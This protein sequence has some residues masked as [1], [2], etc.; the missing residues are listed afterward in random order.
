[1][2]HE[3]FNPLKK[4]FLHT[5][6]KELGEWLTLFYQIRNLC[7]LSFNCAY[8]VQFDVYALHALLTQ[9]KLTKHKK[10]KY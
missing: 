6:K 5:A 7:K 1:M 4:Y 2:T 9:I 3:D 8:Y 10:K